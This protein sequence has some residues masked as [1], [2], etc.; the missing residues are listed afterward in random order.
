[1][2]TYYRIDWQGGM[3]LSDKVFRASDDYVASLFSHLFPLLARGGY[4]LFPS[5]PDDNFT[6]RYEIDR[7]HLSVIELR[8]LAVTPSGKLIRLHFNQNDRDLFQQIPL[9]EAPGGSLLVYLDC[10]STG[11]VSFEQEEIP[12]RDVDYKVVLKEESEKYT[13]PDAVAIA[14]FKADVGWT[15]DSSFIPPCLFLNS[16]PQLMGAA[17]HYTQVLQAFTDQLKLKVHSDAR[18]LVTALLAPLARIGL[19]LEKELP[20]LTPLHFITLVQ[21]VIQS[22]LLLCELDTSYAIP[23][24]AA[25]YDY[26]RAVYHPLRLAELFA[27]GVRLTRMLTEVVATFQFKMPDIP[28]P[29]AP[30]APETPETPVRR[31]DFDSKRRSFKK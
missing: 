4:G 23:D 17:R 20:T 11:Y 1:M 5:A 28:Q 2:N 8:C 27:E 21:Q 25:C 10:S 22:F 24:R 16:D 29:A 19:E 6:F 14:R 3:R 7:H 31:R 15:L 13:N 9:P 18:L 26:I 30:S 12:F